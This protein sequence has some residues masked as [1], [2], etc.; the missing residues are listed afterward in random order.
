[1]RLPMWILRWMHKRRLSR[2][3]LRGTQ[4]HSWFGDRILHKDLW[5]PTRESLARGWLVG[6]PITVIP[7][8]PLQSIIACFAALFVRG[9]IPL[10]IALQFLS[11]PLTAPVHLPACYFVGEVVRGVPPRDAW[12][13]VA[14]SPKQLVKFTREI[15]RGVSPVKAW[16]HIAPTPKHLFTGD[17]AIS[18]Y[19]GAVV[20][21]V[22][23]GVGGYGVLH[24]TWTDKPKRRS[25]GGATPHRAPPQ[26]D[27]SR[28]P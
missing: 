13:P 10:C 11:T 18:L 19:L 5:R 21:G 26:P 8:L 3:G 12:R 23:V 7:F 17:A 1:M 22:L 15:L 16:R 9:N 25:N 20:L 2:R 24:H 4:L 27:P 14:D 6:F 28:M